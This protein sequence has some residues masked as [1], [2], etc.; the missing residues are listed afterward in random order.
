M[1]IG[2]IGTV[3]LYLPVLGT[4][5]FLVMRRREPREWDGIVLGA[6]GWLFGVVIASISL[7]TLFTVQGL[8]L[9]AVVI[10]AAVSIATRRDIETPA[11]TD[12][13]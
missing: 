1:T 7:V 4:I 11:V 12:S 2:A 9:T 10:V 5:V 8:M 13:A 6:S 3:L